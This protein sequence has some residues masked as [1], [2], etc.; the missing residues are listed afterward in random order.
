MSWPFVP[1]TAYATYHEDQGGHGF[2]RVVGAERTLN[3]DAEKVGLVPEPYGHW[4]DET[5]TIY[6]V[7]LEPHGK[8]NVEG[9]DPRPTVVK[10]EKA[11]PSTPEEQ[12]HHKEGGDL[13]PGLQRALHHINERFRLLSD[14]VYDGDE[15]RGARCELITV[16]DLIEAELAALRARPLVGEGEEGGER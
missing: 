8:L 10:A 9:R 2:W 1:A 11:R 7:W 13:G 12:R 3:H 14:L 15:H 16:G 5:P 4:P 6:K